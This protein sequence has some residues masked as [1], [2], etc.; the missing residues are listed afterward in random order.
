MWLQADGRSKEAPVKLSLGPCPGL[1]QSLALLLALNT[2]LQ[3]A[4]LN[5]FYR[6]SRLSP[7][8]WLPQTHLPW[9]HP[10]RLPGVCC[11]CGGVSTHACARVGEAPPRAGRYPGSGSQKPCYR[12]QDEVAAGSGTW[13]PLSQV[14]RVCSRLQRELLWGCGM[15]CVP[16]WHLGTWSLVATVLIAI[17]AVPPQSNRLLPST[18]P[19]FPLH[20]HL[21]PWWAPQ[22]EKKISLISVYICRAAPSPKPTWLKLE[23]ASGSGHPLPLPSLSFLLMHHCFLKGKSDLSQGEKSPRPLFQAI[24]PF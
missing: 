21:Q 17:P 16:A 24:V 7:A 20:G 9:K 22:W 18:V 10:A 1:A 19:L 23:G 3:R 2:W 14:G 13:V 15:L 4:G 11:T 6:P 12:S 5:I 8:P